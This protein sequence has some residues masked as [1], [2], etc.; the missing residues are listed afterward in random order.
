M[1]KPRTAEVHFYEFGIDRWFMSETR[2]RCSL[3]AKGA[4]RELLD[5][6]YK[7]GS[8]PAEP[9]GMAA[10]CGCLIDEM[11]TVLP[12]FRSNFYVSKNDPSRLKN[13][14]ADLFRKNYFSYLKKQASNRTGKGKKSIPSNSS[15]IKELHNGGGTV[16]EPPSNQT[17]RNETNTE[18]RQNEDETKG[19]N[20][21]PLQPPPPAA[22]LPFVR[23][24]HLPGAMQVSDWAETAG[25]IRSFFPVTDD[26][27]ILKIVMEGIKA[28]HEITDAGIAEAVYAVY[29]T[30][31]RSPMLFLTTVPKYLVGKRR[32]AEVRGSPAQ[33]KKSLGAVDLA[34]QKVAERQRTKEHQRT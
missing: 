17:K 27:G 21:A 25:A 30:E 29:G 14:H 7:H 34:L 23:K 16:D 20:E 26:L 1:K 28:D 10:I 18:L 31:Y 8:I 33:P 12:A 11:A 3:A 5:Y 13:I 9:A 32:G 2:L 6:C 19:A 4:Y 22:V 15:R 24:P